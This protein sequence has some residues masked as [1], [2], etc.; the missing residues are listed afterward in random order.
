[1]YGTDAQAK[2]RGVFDKPLGRNAPTILNTTLQFRQHW[3]GVFESVDA[4][5]SHAILGPG[6]GN[7]DNEAA[8]ARLEAIPGYADL[9]KKA[10]PKDEKPIN[11]EN[12]GAAIGAYEKT[13]LTPSRFDAFLD[14]KID[15]LTTAEQVGLR[16]FLDVGC[17]DCHDQRGLGG[18]SY[19]KFGV[20][21]DYW[22]ATKSEPDSGRFKITKNE[23]DRY[24][25]KVAPL[26]NVAM[27]PPYFHDGSVR[28]LPAAVRVMATVQLGNEPSDAETDSI[29]AFLESLTGDLPANFATAPTLPQ[30]QFHS[31][32]KPDSPHPSTSSGR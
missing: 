31:T 24:V 4:Q 1:L 8:M 20:K 10:F 9:F 22:K 2:S 28:T 17:A 6:F 18:N 26:R 13:L 16:K 29:I 5:A 21:S 19:E 12:W 25:F 14:G 7:P 15:A 30:G 32:P 11:A 23:E 3:D 27:T